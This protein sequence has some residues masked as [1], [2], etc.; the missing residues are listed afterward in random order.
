MQSHAIASD[1]A[2]ALQMLSSDDAQYTVAL[3]DLAMPVMDGNEC[4]RRFREF[5]LSSGKPRLRAV[6]V[7]ASG[8]DPKSRAE[9]LA[10][11]FDDVMTKPLTLQQLQKLVAL[12]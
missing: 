5:E 2:M 7:T 11:G 12:P 3:V 6:A 9:C 8:D 1:G 10:A 4:I